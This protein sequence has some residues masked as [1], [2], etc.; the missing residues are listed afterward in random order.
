MVVTG[1]LGAG[2]TEAAG[3]GAAAATLAAGTGAGLAAGACAM[4]AGP[5]ASMPAAANPKKALPIARAV[6]PS[7]MRF[8][9]AS[10]FARR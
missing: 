8:A 10:L 4:A 7:F 2:A 6:V 5:A 9:F 3:D 1:A